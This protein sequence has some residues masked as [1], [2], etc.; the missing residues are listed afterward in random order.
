MSAAEPAVRAHEEW[1]AAPE[2]TQ[3]R[4]ATSTAE[5]RVSERRLRIQAGGGSGE[6]RTMKP[7][8]EQAE[9]SGATL[10]RRASTGN[11][12][13]VDSA[14]ETE[15]EHIAQA[16]HVSGEGREE[17]P[18][19]ASGEAD[20]GEGKSPSS[21]P[22][23]K[24]RTRARPYA[25]GSRRAADHAWVCAPARQA[26]GRQSAI[27]RCRRREE[28][29]ARQRRQAGTSRKRRPSRSEERPRQEVERNE[30]EE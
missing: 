14:G 10:A 24:T 11:Q 30:V 15:R 4:L 28:E 5:E 20:G 23:P 17:E 1:R 6:H 25:V 8:S 27:G 22:L 12:R 19:R 26:S 3:M 29:T 7:A 21:P 2:L 18:R 16:H 9:T 13:D